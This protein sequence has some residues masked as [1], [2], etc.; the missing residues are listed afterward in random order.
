MSPKALFSRPIGALGLLDSPPEPLDDPNLEEALL[1]SS[2]EAPSL[3]PRSTN[4]PRSSVSSS[5][6]PS[7]ALPSSSAALLPITSPNTTG[8][9]GGGDASSGT[10]RRLTE[11]ATVPSHATVWSAPRTI[12]AW[13]VMDRSIGRIAPK[14]IWRVSRRVT[15]K[16]EGFA[17]PSASIML[18]ASCASAHST[19][20]CASE[21]EALA[22]RVFRLPLSMSTATLTE[23]IG[24]G[25]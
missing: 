1:V 12:S 23:E 25:L 20:P 11:H 22:G 5:E 7:W 4:L 8:G 14:V 2:P 13:D 9:A 19:T 17:F 18:D 15:R 10:N 3:L 24:I 21:A 16:E 6:A